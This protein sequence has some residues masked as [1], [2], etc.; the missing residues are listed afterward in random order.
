MPPTL[1]ILESA[2]PNAAVNHLA[3]VFRKVAIE[4]GAI[5]P[6]GSSIIISTSPLDA[7]AERGARAAAV[8]ANVVLRRFC[9]RMIAHLRTRFVTICGDRLP[10]QRQEERE[11]P[12]PVRSNSVCRVPS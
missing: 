5:V 1:G 9:R 11:Y 12:S 4:S 6:M 10:S 8:T 3:D 7:R 2:Y